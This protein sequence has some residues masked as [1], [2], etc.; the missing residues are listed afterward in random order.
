MG[1]KRNVK[2]RAAKLKPAPQD[3]QVNVGT[4][5]RKEGQ[6][7]DEIVNVALPRIYWEML[8]ADT[9][10]SAEYIRRSIDPNAILYRAI[11]LNIQNQADIDMSMS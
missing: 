6:T 4:A 5:S 9:I 8:L 3:F 11:A 1:Q 2:K 10:A 7:S